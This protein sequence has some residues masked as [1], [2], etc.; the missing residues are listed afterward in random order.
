MSARGLYQHVFA[1]V[2]TFFFR[3]SPQQNEC[4]LLMNVN[5]SYDEFHVE[6]VFFSR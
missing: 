3:E 5:I 6:R 1:G 4:E 2:K